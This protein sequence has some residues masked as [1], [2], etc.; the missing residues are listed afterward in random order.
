M[1]SQSLH[2]NDQLRKAIGKLI[3]GLE[4]RERE[5]RERRQYH[6]FNLGMKVG[7]CQRSPS[8]NI[9]KYCDAWALDLSIGGIGFMSEQA[10]NVGDVVF[11]SFENLI[12]THAYIPIIVR[13]TRHLVGSVHQVNGQFDYDAETES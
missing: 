13:N 2:S 12:G 10:I 1:S 6:R 11:I 7:L 9:E 3:R 8:G 5:L 4:K